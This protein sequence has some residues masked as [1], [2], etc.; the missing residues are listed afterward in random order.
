[1]GYTNT[2]HNYL[3]YLQTSKMTMVH[4]DVI[5]DED[6]VMQVSLEREL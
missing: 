2:P 6:K 4:R 3:V 1:M 5:F